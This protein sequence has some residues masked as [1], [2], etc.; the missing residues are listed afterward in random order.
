MLISGAEEREFFVWVDPKNFLIQHNLGL[1]GGFSGGPMEAGQDTP[2][3]LQFVPNPNVLPGFLSPFHNGVIRQ[4]RVEYNLEMFRFRNFPTHPSRLHAI[5]LLDTRESADEYRNT[6][7]EHV[8]GR[9]LKRAVTQ[10]GY[11]F[12][13]HDANWIDFLR[14]DN[15]KDQATFDECH[16]RYWLGES[17]KEHNFMHLGAPWQANSV[18]EIL[19]YGRLSFPDRGLAQDD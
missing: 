14:L 6:H 15:M 7:P 12:S 16:Q 4:Y 8:D 3:Y 17:V 11:K 10:G 18:M 19:F 1:I 9:I 2:D 5:Y 13:R